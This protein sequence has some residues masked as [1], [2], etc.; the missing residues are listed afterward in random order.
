MP[1]PQLRKGENQSD[2]I[3]R[4]MSN[5]TMK[6]EFSDNKQRL[7][8]AHSTWRKSKQM[9]NL[10]LIYNVPIQI[11]EARE[12]SGGESDFHIEGI[13]INAVTTENNHKFLAD[14]LKTATSSLKGVP[15]LK[16]HDNFVDSIMG[17]VIASDFNEEDQNIK[18]KAV[19]RDEKIKQMIKDGRLTSVS[20]GAS[21]EDIDE[22]DDLLVP[23][24]IEFKEL[25]LVAVPADSGAQITPF[26][27]SNF[28]SAIEEA[29][30][31]KIKE[32]SFNCECI[33][34][35][36]KITSDKHCKDIKC[37]KCGG[38]MRRAERPGPGQEK[39]DSDS[40][41][42]VVDTNKV[43]K[44]EKMTEDKES[45]VEFVKLEDF[46]KLQEKT[47]EVQKKID[48]QT[49]LLSDILS[50]VSVKEADTD[51]P[52][53]EEKP[54]EPKVD[55]PK[56]ESAVEEPKEEPKEESKEEPV[57]EPNKED[58]EEDEEDEEESEDDT[59][60]E[61]SGY[62]IKQGY[63]SFSILRNKY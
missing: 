34:C 39:L 49:E 20:I 25:S 10:D 30:K 38:Q 47:E 58:S 9:N 60:E 50:K 1:L 27:G 55:E 35:G 12:T 44:E 19:V 4:F 13:A 40:N 63:K 61:K 43:K 31:S 23:R 2:F 32:Q 17:R 57:K 48:A 21:V 24:G 46:S 51:E 16:D 53:E 14:E 59:T 33:K 37:S 6:K 36:Y 54:E 3:A 28:S 42:I 22:E 8:V 45:K 56:E 15:L 18:F 41:D 11:T 62:T 5:E 29:W 7:A 52:K 26:K